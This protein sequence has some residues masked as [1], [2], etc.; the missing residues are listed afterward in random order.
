M[1]DYKI[2]GAESTALLEKAVDQYLFEGWSLHGGLILDSVENNPVVF[3]QV[4]T[5]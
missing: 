2:L 3:Y 1:S 5:R 4:V